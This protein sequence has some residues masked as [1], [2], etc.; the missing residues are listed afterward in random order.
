MG[1]GVVGRVG[2]GGGGG[3]KRHFYMS[4]A[5]NFTHIAKR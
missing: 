2:W 1:T 5:E 4:S 3:I